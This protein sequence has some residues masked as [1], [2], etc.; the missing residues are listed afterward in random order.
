MPIRVV[1]FDCDG[2]LT[3][4]K[5]SWEYL[6]RRLNLWD[7]HADAYQMMFRNGLIS[8]EEFCE[9]DALLWKGL[10]TSRIDEI[11]SEVPLQEGAA[12]AVRILKDLGIYTVII[13]SGLSFLVDRIKRLLCIDQ[14]FSNELEAI[15][16]YL[17]GRTKINVPYN[18]K[19]QLVQSLLDSMGVSRAE[20]CAVGDGDGDAGM[21]EQVGVPIHLCCEGLP[22]DGSIN[23][24]VDLLSTVRF[25]KDYG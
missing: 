5:S 17:T 11:I 23:R 24:H 19:G 9:R 3:T 12:G 1:F 7:N 20:S 4:I 25:I 8:Y 6:H 16:G 15:D 21:F 2:T 13:S 18:C 10:S 14:A 22:I